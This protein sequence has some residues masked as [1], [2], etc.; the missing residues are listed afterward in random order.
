MTEP[1]SGFGPAC[2]AG[3]QAA[4]DEEV[5]FMDCGASLDPAELPGVVGPVTEGSAI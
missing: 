5:G 3:L 1:R 4:R 2:Y